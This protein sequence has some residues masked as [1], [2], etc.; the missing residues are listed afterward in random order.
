MIVNAISS[1]R[2][3]IY[4][5]HFQPDVRLMPKNWFR[6]ALATVESLGVSIFDGIVSNSMGMPVEREHQNQVQ[7]Q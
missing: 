5:F 6:I 7:S 4:V 2:V 3:N 1:K